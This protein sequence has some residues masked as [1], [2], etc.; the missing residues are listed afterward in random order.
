[1]KNILIV[2]CFIL[3]IVSQTLSAQDFPQS[4]NKSPINWQDWEISISTEDKLE[5]VESLSRNVGIDLALN[6]YSYTI[7]NVINNFHIIDF[8][9]DGQ[10]D[11][12]YAGF[13]GKRN[14]GIILYELNDGYCK[15]PITLLG[16]II[17][18]WRSDIWTPISFKIHNYRCCNGYVDFIETYSPQFDKNVRLRYELS[19]KVAFVHGTLI[20]TQFYA[21][22]LFRIITDD[23]PLSITPASSEKLYDYELKD[24]PVVDKYP[25][26]DVHFKYDGNIVANF[27][28]NATGYMLAERNNYNGDTWY[29]VMMNT[30]AKPSMS[31]FCAAGDNNTHPYKTMGWINSKDLKLLEEKELIF[32]NPA[33]IGIGGSIRSGTYIKSK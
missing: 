17:E 31:V 2:F 10:Y 23:T 4:I 15:K 21:P 8:N 28:S 32:W 13:L 24:A 6:Y 5:I 11:V 22:K 16:E 1:M 3:T 25:Y 29:F 9:N 26:K 14:N 7:K 27:A 12:I 30:T 20:P 33:L 18:I 19:S